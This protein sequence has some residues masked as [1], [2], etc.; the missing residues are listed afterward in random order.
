MMSRMWPGSESPN[1]TGRF[2]VLLT[3]CAADQQRYY[4]AVPTLGVYRS[5]DSGATW[6]ATGNAQLKNVMG[7]Q[8]AVASTT[9]ILLAVHNSANKNVPVNGDLVATNP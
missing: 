4:A 9:R 3:A 1:A 8:E 5:S 2:R 7:A 6:T